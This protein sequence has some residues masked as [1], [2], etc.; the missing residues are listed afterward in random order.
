MKTYIVTG[1]VTVSVR[2]TVQARSPEE[3]KEK[4]FENNLPTLCYQCA[5][6][7]GIGEWSLSGELDGEVQIDE[8]QEA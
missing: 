6:N 7:D 4:A 5:S 2:T 8:A 3:A 1:T